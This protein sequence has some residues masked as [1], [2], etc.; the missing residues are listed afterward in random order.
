[1]EENLST[2]AKLSNDGLE[3]QHPMQSFP[4]RDLVLV[5]VPKETRIQ[6]SQIA[7]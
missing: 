4:S 7:S 3:L 6:G 2:D 1:M 5:P